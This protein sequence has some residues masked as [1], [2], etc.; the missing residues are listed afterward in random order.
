MTKKEYIDT[1][2]NL[3]VNRVRF[4]A[5][6]VVND[7]VDFSV[8]EIVGI[9]TSLPLFK[10]ENPL[11]R[12]LCEAFLRAQKEVN[13]NLVALSAPKAPKKLVRQLRNFVQISREEMGQRLLASINA[14]NINYKSCTQ[15]EQGI[16]ENFIK[17][18]DQKLNLEYREFYREK[19]SSSC[20]VAFDIKEY[21]LNG[22]NYLLNLSNLTPEQKLTRFEINIVLP[23][24]YYFFK[25]ESGGVKIVNLYSRDTAYF[26]FSCKNVHLTFS[27]IGGIESSTHACLNLKLSIAL[28][29]KEQKRFYFNYGENKY[30][31]S[32]FKDAENFF[33]ISQVKMR[34]VFDLKIMSR[35]KALDAK[36]NVAL[37]KRIY[38]HW[39]DY[40]TDYEAEEEYLKLKRQFVERTAKGYQIKE[41]SLKQLQIFDGRA[42]KRIFIVKGESKFLLAGDTKY[43]NFDCVRREL[44]A[45]N[46]EIYLSF[47]A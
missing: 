12:E 21:L 29:P 46:N 36:F 27:S 38:A 31:F 44:F 43:F 7:D 4:H 3:I 11:G 16:D 6:V 39:L 30:N 42:Y 10:V 26:N 25:R 23:R 34:E 8:L 22:K 13:F 47:G 1:L 2:A 15:F 14:L 37:P 24:G 28:K 9:D 40:K 19:K 33:A 32:S 20:G 41:N 17:L 5:P 45:K 18:D 35:D